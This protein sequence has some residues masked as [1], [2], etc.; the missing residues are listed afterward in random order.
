MLGKLAL[1]M[2]ELGRVQEQANL[3]EED[4]IMMAGIKYFPEERKAKDQQILE[5]YRRLRDKLER[6]VVA[7]ALKIEE[8]TKS[9]RYALYSNK[10][11][12]EEENATE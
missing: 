8:A 6:E 2:L 7:L 10:E 1:K 9:E 11:Y 4:I 5:D 3:L 12:K